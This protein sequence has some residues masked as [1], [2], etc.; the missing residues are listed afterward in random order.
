MRHAEN[1]YAALQE[2]ALSVEVD[3]EQDRGM[4]RGS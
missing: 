4:G 2:C 1:L 3:R